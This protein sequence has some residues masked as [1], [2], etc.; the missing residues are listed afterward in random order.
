MTNLETSWPYWMMSALTLGVG[1][2][3]LFAPS[4]VRAHEDHPIPAASASHQPAA[5][6]AAHEHATKSE[7]GEHAARE[8]KTLDINALIERLRRTHAIGMFTKLA[9][10]SDAMDLMDQ[11]KAWR[12]HHR[13]CSLKDLRARFDGLLL[14]VLA[15]LDG[16]P[17]LARDISRAREDIWRSL[18]EV[19]A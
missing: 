14:K 7:G 9:I 17:A 15:L 10:R 6:S 11:V 3:I 5:A 18:L 8:R 12:A 16:D 4:C 1:I 13:D 19:K 2:G